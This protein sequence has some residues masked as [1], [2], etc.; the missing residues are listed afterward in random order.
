[1][2]IKDYYSILGVGKQATED[3]MKSAYR[4]LAKQY[5]PDLNPGNKQAEEKFKEIN[6]AYEVLSDK[7]KRAQYEQVKEAQSRGYDFSNA[8]QG[9]GQRQSYGGSGGV[10]INDILSGM[11][12]GMGG[13]AKKGKQDFGQ[14]ENIFDMFFD[15]NTSTARE[16]DASPT[17]G[18]DVTVRI[19][20]PFALAMSGGETIIKVPRDAVC[21]RCSGTGTEPGAKVATCTTCGGRGKIQYA[22]GGFIINKTCPRC[23]GRGK[24]SSLECARC[25]GSGTARETQK[26]RVKVPQG[27]FDGA[28]I[29]IKAQG[30]MRPGQQGRGSLY[31]IFKVEDGGYTRENDDIYYPLKLT[32]KQAEKG[33]EVKVPTITGGIIMKVPA[34]TEN[35]KLL[36][37][38]GRGAVN[39][40][41]GIR[42]DFYVKVKVK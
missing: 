37:V 24:A 21:D 33:M 40:K 20:I 30:D 15:N 12:S 1:M 31:V 32:K 2:S 7:K 5:H 11:F 26:I 8:R 10:D 16:E 41:S 35:G 38:K 4:K 3:Q 29:K 13:G 18:D 19:E 9:T 25:S 34:K 42:G 27:V 17:V 14:F 39:M 6:E 36:R 23:G 28:K 22:Q